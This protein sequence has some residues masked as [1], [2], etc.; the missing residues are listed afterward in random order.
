MSCAPFTTFYLLLGAPAVSH[1][2]VYAQ[3]LIKKS[4]PGS[5]AF[6]EGIE[7]IRS[8]L[9]VRPHRKTALRHRLFLSWRENGRII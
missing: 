3:Q 6:I 2:P 9:L 8:R 1:L 4:L 7:E 5:R